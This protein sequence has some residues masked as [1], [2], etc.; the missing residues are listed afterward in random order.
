ME[1]L[2]SK[3]I[4]IPG[5]QEKDSTHNFHNTICGL[6]KY[7]VFAKTTFFVYYKKDVHF[8]K[9]WIFLKYVNYFLFR[10]CLPSKFDQRYDHFKAKI[11][12]RSKNF[13]P[14]F[15]HTRVCPFRCS[16]HMR[17]TSFW[18]KV[19]QHFQYQPL[20]IFR[21]SVVS[22]SD[23]SFVALKRSNKTTE[24]PPSDQGQQKCWSHS[25]KHACTVC[26]GLNLKCVLC[27]ACAF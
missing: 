7:S 25:L 1:W 10:V 21:P 9:C 14:E 13:G 16:Y 18:R 17:A 8:N 4:V 22:A 23:R 11:S 24:T 12:Q 27:S 19:K 5:G 26:T 2:L 20:Q 3:L 15:S 6:Q